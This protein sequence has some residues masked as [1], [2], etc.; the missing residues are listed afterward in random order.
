MVNTNIIEARI[1]DKMADRD[2]RM[3]TTDA[4]LQI[5][6]RRTASLCTDF[7]E[8]ADTIEI[9]RNKRVTGN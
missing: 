6:P 2:R 5:Y 3:F 7:N 8:F 1:H 4:E 9:D